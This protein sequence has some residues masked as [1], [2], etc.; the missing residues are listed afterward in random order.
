VLLKQRSVTAEIAAL[1]AQ[2]ADAR[3]ALAWAKAQPPRVVDPSQESPETQATIRM[4]VAALKSLGMA[5]RLWA[6]DH[7]GTQMPT[8]SSQ[9]GAATEGGGWPAQATV[10]QFEFINQGRTLSP[11]EAD[12]IMMRDQP[13]QLHDGSWLRH[14][15][16]VDGQVMAFVSADGNFDSFEQYHTAAPGS[17]NPS[18]PAIQPASGR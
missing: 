1:T 5:G 14:Y 7:G 13:V 10:N 11:I 9:M 3:K 16:M 8:N 18:A 17:V 15:A 2:L 6:N 4:N 12:L